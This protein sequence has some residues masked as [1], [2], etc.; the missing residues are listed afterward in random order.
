MA[1]ETWKKLKNFHLVPH[2]RKQIL[3]I[4]VACPGW[5]WWQW[6]S[7]LNLLLLWTD[8]HV[9]SHVR[10]GGTRAV[11]TIGAPG[12][13]GDKRRSG[14]GPEL[15]GSLGPRSPEFLRHTAVGHVRLIQ[16]PRVTCWVSRGNRHFS[17]EINRT[18]IRIQ[19]I[20]KMWNWNTRSIQM[21]CAFGKPFQVIP[22][23]PRDACLLSL[24]PGPHW[25]EH[26]RDTLHPP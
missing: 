5:A 16:H 2:I 9:R 10:G 13:R 14:A 22:Q 21:F 26:P 18:V 15:L 4:Q 23:R 8:T 1:V 24:L 12:C 17:I 7:F 6:H 11:S 20:N 25:G 19:I 3:Q